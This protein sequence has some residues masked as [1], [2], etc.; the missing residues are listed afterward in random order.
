MQAH[1][2]KQILN[3]AQHIKDHGYAIVKNFISPQQCQEAKNEID[4][5]VD[6]FEPSP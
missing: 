1:I 4:R 5:L 6:N 2:A 3:S